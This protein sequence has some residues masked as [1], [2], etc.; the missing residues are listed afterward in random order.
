[1]AFEVVILMSGG[2]KMPVGGMGGG[3]LHNCVLYVR[4]ENKMDRMQLN[5][6]LEETVRQ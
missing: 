2:R 6:E 4:P 3:V 5:F 1:M